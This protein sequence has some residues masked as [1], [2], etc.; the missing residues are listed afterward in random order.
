[1]KTKEKTKEKSKET[2]KKSPDKKTDKSKDSP[3]KNSINNNNIN[4]QKPQSPFLFNAFF[5]LL[6]SF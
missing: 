1:M 6:I 2:S 3:P 4:I 5:K